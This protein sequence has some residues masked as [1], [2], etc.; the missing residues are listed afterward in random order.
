MRVFIAGATGALGVPVVRRL[1]AEGHTVIGLARTHR[2][3]QPL[4]SL[5]AQVVVADAL[6]A[7]ALG[8]AVRQARPE[9]VVHALTAIPPHGP[10]R[11]ADLNA[12][13]ALRVTGTK[14]LLAA[15]IAAG[16]RRV[17]AES[18]VLIYGFGEHGYTALTEDTPV[19]RQ[20]PSAWLQAS[21]DALIAEEALI[22]ASTRAGRIEGIVLRFGGFYGPGAGT[23]T[24]IQMLRR[25]R[26]PITPGAPRHA[27]PWIHISDA[28]VAV[29][30]ALAQGR[31]GQM[32]NIADDEAVSASDLISHLAGAVGAPQPW[33]MPAWLLRLAAPFAAAAWLDT[34]LCV[35]NAKAKQELGWT[36]Q[37]PTFREGM[38][39]M[40]RSLHPDKGI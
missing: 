19:A 18:M 14:N 28:A 1:R 12:T 37:F 38:A 23:E 32:Y 25:R 31:S 4:A 27:I 21:L 22:L 10:R 3:T 35:S 5:G 15:A 2:R 7:D 39:D 13:N 34:T 17:V 24:M 11:P 33:S 16:A 9:L 40:A 6:D 26:L 8:D 20:A 30:A 29:T 36:P